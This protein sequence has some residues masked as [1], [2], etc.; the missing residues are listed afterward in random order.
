MAKCPAG[1]ECKKHSPPPR[2]PG[3]NAKIAAS[4]TGKRASAKARRNM[5]N[6]F[7]GRVL[8]QAHRESISRSLSGK[9]MPLSVPKIC[10]CGV[11]FLGV[12]SSK[13]HSDECRAAYG[14]TW[15]RRV[16]EPEWA[17]FRESAEFFATST[18]WASGTLT[19]TQN[20]S[21]QQSTI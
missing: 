8:S 5:S 7:K 15:R 3:W 9:T 2:S 17:H 1:C 16:H 6:A 19:M 11:E 21:K 12:S 14:S 4:K 10:P 18:T 13:Y 20:F